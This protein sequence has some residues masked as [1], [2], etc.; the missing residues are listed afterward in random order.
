MQTR[1]CEVFSCHGRQ[2][3]SH[4]NKAL[5]SSLPAIQDHME[6]LLTEYC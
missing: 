2:V 3:I 6:V 1:D 4:L 5:I